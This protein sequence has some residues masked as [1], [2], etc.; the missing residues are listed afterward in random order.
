MK[1]N[2]KECDDKKH[3]QYLNGD[4]KHSI[5]KFRT[6]MQESCERCDILTSTPTTYEVY[7]FREILNDKPTAESI[8][9]QYPVLASAVGLSVPSNV[10]TY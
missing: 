4:D 8:V 1:E 7:I 2:D 6:Y 3:R 5:T 9:K 10:K